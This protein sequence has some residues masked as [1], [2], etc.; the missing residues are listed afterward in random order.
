RTVAST[1]LSL[2][3]IVQEQEDYEAARALATEALG[4]YRSVGDSRSE[5]LSLA[6]L[7]SITTSAGDYATAWSHLR[8]SIGTFQSIGDTGGVAFVLERFS[9]LAMAQSR[10]D[11]AL[12]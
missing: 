10:H 8:D 7:G 4:I 12:R 11:G 6:N 5:A 2:A 9:G 3:V 1:T